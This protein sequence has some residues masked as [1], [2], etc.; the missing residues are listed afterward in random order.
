MAKKEKIEQKLYI[1][2]KIVI[3]E[4]KNFVYEML[5]YEYTKNGIMLIDSKDTEQKEFKGYG[6]SNIIVRGNLR[7]LQVIELCGAP[8][9]FIKENFKPLKLKK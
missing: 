4:S 2:D 6:S 9:E 7:F 3:E 5:V 1:R 8:L